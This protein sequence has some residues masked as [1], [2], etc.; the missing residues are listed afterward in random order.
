MKFLKKKKNICRI[1]GLEK[2]FKFLGS[3]EEFIKICALLYSFV[4]HSVN[5]N[6]ENH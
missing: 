6:D 5:F 4:K 1:E 2:N 3:I